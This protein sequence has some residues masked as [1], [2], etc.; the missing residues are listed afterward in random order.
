MNEEGEEQK[1]RV[2]LEF[3]DRPKLKILFTS[4]GAVERGGCS[5]VVLKLP[6]SNLEK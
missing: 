6:P 5:V 2:Q 4:P 3:R 1:E